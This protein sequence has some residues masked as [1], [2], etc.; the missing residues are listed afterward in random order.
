MFN[1]VQRRNY[2][3]AFSGII[4]LAG[5][6]A[7]AISIATYPE[8]SPVRLSIDFVGGSLVE[9]QFVPAPGKAQTG[10]INEALIQSA[11]QDYSS[12]IRIQ[13]LGAAAG[14]T[15][16]GNAQ[17]STDTSLSRWQV[18]LTYLDN[19]TS[20]KVKAALNAK[21]QAIGYQ[22]D[23]GT[24]ANNTVSPI[25]GSQVTTAAVIAVLV[26]TL[27]VL[28]WIWYAFRQVTDPWRYAVC[29][30]LALIHDVLV[31][32]GVMSIMGL[33]FKWEADALFLT[34]LLTVVGYSVQDTIV[35]F[36]RIRENSA[37]HR[38]EPY[39]MIVNRSILETLGRSISMQLVVGFVMISLFLMGGSSIRQF[40]GVLLIGLLSGTY[41]STFTAIPLLVAWEEGHLFV[42]RKQ[43]VVSPA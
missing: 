27:V 41:S 37:R 8:H 24:F 17:Q 13:R 19:D 28:G 35:V 40:V 26:A 23:E 34:G 42:T 21:A 10:Q 25:V 33:V 16:G 29:A 2:F 5:L 14:T 36:D 7:M 11:F 6:I 32:T 12:D 9:F 30:I 43:T 39:E 3:F 31:M 15:E 1:I 38:G 4:I 20:N 18:R 22:L